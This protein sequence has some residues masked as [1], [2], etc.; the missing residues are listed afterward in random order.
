MQRIGVPEE[1]TKGG[2]G[3]NVKSYNSR[4]TVINKKGLKWHIEGSHRV[5]ENTDP[6]W[7]TLG[8]NF[9]KNNE[10]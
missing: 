2:L 9:S 10:T 5:P 3:T 7:P 1:K 6:E 4:K 8:Y